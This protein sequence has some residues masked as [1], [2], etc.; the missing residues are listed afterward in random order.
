MVE[1]PLQVSMH[2]LAP[3]N[4]RGRFWGV[5][6][7]LSSGITPTGIIL[8]GILIDVV[9]PFIIT[10]VSGIIISLTAIIMYKSKAMQNY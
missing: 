9:Q 3:E 7:T 5:M 8:F 1:T 6:G 10:M 4:I 2:R